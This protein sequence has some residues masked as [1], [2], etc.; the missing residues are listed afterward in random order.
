MEPRF[1][2]ASTMVA[3]FSTLQV[4]AA[5]AEEA[6]ASSSSIPTLIQLYSTKA[7]H[8]DTNATLS[9][10]TVLSYQAIEVAPPST[11]GDSLLL[12][13]TQNK[14]AAVVNPNLGVWNCLVTKASKE[15]AL[16]DKLLMVPD[17]TSHYCFTV[18]VADPSKVEPVI[19][20]LH[21]ALVRLMIEK[22]STLEDESLTTSLLQLHKTTFGL[23][24]N[25]EESSNKLTALTPNDSDANIKFALMI[26]ALMPPTVNATTSAD[27]YKETQS[28]ALIMYHL[29]KY[30]AALNAWLCFVSE[31]T[32]EVN[33]QNQPTMTVEQLANVWKDWAQSKEPADNHPA[34]YAPGKHQNDLI[35]TVLLRNA[36]CPGHWEASKDSLWKALPPTVDKG[37]AGVTKKETTGDDSWLST[38]RESVVTDTSAVSATPKKAAAQPATPKAKEDAA[39]ASSFFENL[40]NS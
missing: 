34:M 19:S 32:P 4:S 40:L 25:D 28:Q 30:A 1:D 36:H 29:R 6:A 26:V 12:G 39:A 17:A 24:P 23:A 33:E 15:T 3:L 22:A 16:V 9:G 8:L 27:A 20:S 2:P 21:E 5:N 7:I 38:L 18:D 13:Q 14:A 10:H 11:E 37:E 35:D 31:A